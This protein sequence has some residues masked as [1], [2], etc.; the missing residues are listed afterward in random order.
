MHVRENR[1]DE[2]KYTVVVVNFHVTVADRRKFNI[3][4]EL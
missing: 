3:S 4:N 1:W 2:L